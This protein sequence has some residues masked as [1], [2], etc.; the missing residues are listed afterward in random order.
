MVFYWDF[1][2]AFDKVHWW[3]LNEEMY[4]HRF[5][6]GHGHYF[7]NWL[8]GS[9]Q[10]VQVGDSAS[11][12]IEV[13]SSI[14]QGSIF[15]GKVGFTIVINSLFRRLKK[16]AKQLGIEEYFVIKSYAD[17]TKF[18]LP[19][20]KG[21]PIEIEEDIHQQMINEFH[22]WVKDRQLF[23]NG[24][25]SV[26][27]SIGGSLPDDYMVFIDG[28]EIKSSKSETDLGIITTDTLSWKKHLQTKSNDA[29]RIIYSLNYLIPRISYSRQL[30]IYNA[31]VRSILI[32]GSTITFPQ[33][34]AEEKILRKPFKLFW[35][36]AGK[37]PEGAKNRSHLGSS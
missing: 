5:S 17:D 1:E 27:L 2:K 30:M 19:I 14:K 15:A 23:I 32:Y 18:C 21:V 37:P 28:N 34:Q 9:R 36:L 24:K 29:Q 4:L 26:K 8:R 20:R 3:T 10:Y 35:K 13:T 25:K 22:G 7:Q 33:N 6:N 11:E 31:L 12:T 16:K